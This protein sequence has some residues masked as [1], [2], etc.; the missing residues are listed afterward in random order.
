MNSP[1][2]EDQP[3]EFRELVSFK[4]LALANRI[5]AAAARDVKQ[6][7]D[8]SLMEWRVIL[9]VAIEEGASPAQIASTAGVDKSQISRAVHSLAKQDLL[10]MESDSRHPKRMRLY[11]TEAGRN[12]HRE[13]YEAFI[14]RERRLV[15]GLTLRNMGALL[16]ILDRL[17]SNVS[18]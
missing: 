10:R 16:Q 14:A 9:Q 4:I 7:A 2:S 3:F 1:Q 13:H 15:H 8:V 6:G 17:D 12:I 5:A 18:S 11:L